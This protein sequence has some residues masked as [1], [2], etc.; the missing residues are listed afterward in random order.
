MLVIS[1]QGPWINDHP[2]NC[3]YQVCEGYR[4][5]RGIL[6]H[7]QGCQNSYQPSIHVLSESLSWNIRIML[8][9]IAASKCFCQKP[10]YVSQ[11]PVRIPGMYPPQFTLTGAYTQVRWV[12]YVY[13][14]VG[15]ATCIVPWSGHHCNQRWL[16]KWTML[17]TVSLPRVS[18]IHQSYI[19]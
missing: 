19:K 11:L 10:L 1:F 14:S 17:L 5:T 18:Y 12:M 4:H 7:H 2:C 3:Q 13:I 6:T 15:D 8:E 9:N 16:H